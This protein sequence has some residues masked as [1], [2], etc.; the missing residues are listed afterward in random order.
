M[1]AIACIR[2]A[3]SGWSRYFRL[4]LLANHTWRKTDSTMPVWQAA[5]D[6]TGSW[7]YTR[8]GNL[9]LVLEDSSAGAVVLRQ[10]HWNWQALSHKSDAALTGKGLLRTAAGDTGAQ[11]VWVLGDQVVA[12]YEFPPDEIKGRRP[13]PAPDAQPVPTPAPVES[14][15]GD[16][17]SIRCLG[18]GKLSF[19]AP[20]NL[21]GGSAAPEF[22]VFEITDVQNGRVGR[23]WFAGVELGLGVSVPMPGSSVPSL[24]GPQGF[25]EGLTI[26]GPAGKPTQFTT[27]RPQRL[28][29][30]AN[31]TGT[32]M[33]SSVRIGQIVSV[34]K[35]GLGFEG[36]AI[37]ALPGCRTTVIRGA[38]GTDILPVDL[39]SISTGGA[40]VNVF[41]AA[42]GPFELIDIVKKR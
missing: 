9:V 11:L 28:E 30:F 27:T 2:P 15:V 31:T 5:A 21:G 13:T 33:S 39:P 4:E 8:Q 10:V 7:I 25:R 1:L 16:L 38:D 19:T 37:A 3:N 41:S 17:F 35:T 34:S 42:K 18:G 20:N 12:H 32:L 22:L 23:Y 29:D 40:R 24:P 36:D 6:H 26:V 14:P